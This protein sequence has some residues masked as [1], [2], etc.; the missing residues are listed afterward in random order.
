MCEKSQH[1]LSVIDFI[2]TENNAT[3]V[4]FTGYDAVLGKGF[5]GEVKFLGGMPFGD[6]IHLDRTYL[7][8]EC[9]QYVRGALIKKYN[10]GELS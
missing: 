7:S 3:F 1:T 6:I 10:D 5:E 4:K 9:R 8:S 2:R